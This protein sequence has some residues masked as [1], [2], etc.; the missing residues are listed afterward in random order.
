MNLWGKEKKN[1]YDITQAYDEF[2]DCLKEFEIKAGSV[3]ISRIR[4]DQKGKPKKYALG[5]RPIRDFRDASVEATLL[6]DYGGGEYELL[7]YKDTAGSFA[8]VRTLHYFIDGPNSEEDD[9]QQDPFKAMAYRSLEKQLNSPNNNDQMIQLIVEMIKSSQGKHNDISEQLDNLAKLKSLTASNVPIIPA[10]SEIGAL[11]NAVATLVP[12]FIASK[13]GMPANVSQT[14]AQP[15]R[16]NLAEMPLPNNP[17]Q[18][19]VQDLSGGNGRKTTPLSIQQEAF[20]ALFLNTFKEAIIQGVGD[21]EL[22]GMIE[23]MTVNCIY[24]INP[25]DYHDVVRNFAEGYNA[26]DLDKMSKGF[27]DIMQFGGIPPERAARV[28]ALLISLYQKSATSES[29][30]NKA[31]GEG[32]VNE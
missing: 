23:S 29:V 2:Q 21:D 30:K 4:R 25:E 28:K 31:D 32:A 18:P 15:Q 8:L 26:T 10:K 14:I 16:G 1:G 7:V 19:N 12:A 27:D 13:S 6:E 9:S 17:T 11:I 5:P 24:W 22:A 3:K 20:E